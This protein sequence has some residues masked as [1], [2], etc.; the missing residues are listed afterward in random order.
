MM[1]GRKVW[2]VMKKM[3]MM[4]MVMK[5]WVLVASVEE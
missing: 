4:K 3:E 1:M 5:V 2:V